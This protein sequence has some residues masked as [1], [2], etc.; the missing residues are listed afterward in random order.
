MTYTTLNTALALAWMA[1]FG[2][3][4]IWADWLR[5][6]R[7]TLARWDSNVRALQDRTFANVRKA[8]CPSCGR[9]MHVEGGFYDQDK[10]ACNGVA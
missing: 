8:L 9:S 5:T 6:E 1:A 10:G 2:A 7:R 4:W 3:L